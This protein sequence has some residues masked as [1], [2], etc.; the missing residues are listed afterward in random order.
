MSD[1]KNYD[2]DTN[3]LNPGIYTEIIAKIQSSN[4]KIPNYLK[5]SILRKNHYQ[6]QNQNIDPNLNI[7]QNQAQ[8][9]ED[10]YFLR[11]FPTIENISSHKGYSSGYQ[12]LKITGKGFNP[13]DANLKVLID[14]NEC[15]KIKVNSQTEI[16]CITKE[17]IFVNNTIMIEKLD[18]TTESKFKNYKG[19][20]GLKFKKE[21]ISDPNLI[22]E[23]EI[24]LETKLPIIPEIII[25]EDKVIIRPVEPPFP[26]SPTDSKEIITHKHTP[27][28]IQPRPIEPEINPPILLSPI[29]KPEPILIQ[30]QPIENNEEQIKIQPENLNPE[31]I[32]HDETIPQI[33]P[34]IILPPLTVSTPTIEHEETSNLD[35]IHT[36]EITIPL[37]TTS[38]LSLI[39]EN[40]THINIHNHN[41][42]Q[43]QNKIHYE[44]E[45]ILETTMKLNLPKYTHASFN[46]FFV[47][48]FTGKYK[49][50]SSFSGIHSKIFLNKYI[51][52]T[53]SPI[54]II[55]NHNFPIVDIDLEYGNY[56]TNPSLTQSDWID[57]NKDQK[58][59]I[60]I[61][62]NILKEKNHF[63]LGVEIDPDTDT[64]EVNI[65]QSNFNNNKVPIIKKIN[66]IPKFSRDLY[67]IPILKF[68]ETF[69]TMEFYCQGLN[70]NNKIEIYSNDTLKNLYDKFQKMH[71]TIFKKLTMRK[72]S[73][74]EFMNLIPLE[75]ELGEHVD[76]N[77]TENAN[78]NENINVVNTSNTNE[79]EHENELEDNFREFSYSNKI[80][81]EDLNKITEELYGIY[82]RFDLFN[83]QIKI[84]TDAINNNNSTLIVKK[85][86]GHTFIFFIDGYENERKYRLENYCYTKNSI[87]KNMNHVKLLRKVK[88]NLEG[89]Y[90]LNVYNKDSNENQTSQ[91]IDL[92]N[93]NYEKIFNNILFM[94][95]EYE[96][97]G[98]INSIEKELFLKYNNKVKFLIKK[99]FS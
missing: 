55:D 61:H 21:K 91:L 56:F 8:P 66:I 35:N 27:I 93:P 65:S 12:I 86:I 63:Q 62:N 37:T 64:D 70:N 77:K 4:T 52:G 33:Q 45:I 22:K 9:S 20:K 11:V 59:P 50:I 57:L 43:N 48:P 26:N 72:Y 5:R 7:N 74:D 85:I 41:G 94:Y 98:L 36:T 44:E 42:T 1:F 76:L 32:Q 80:K 46:G 60:E 99:S 31:P 84:N 3:Y 78:L 47:A 90:K 75:E 40:Y 73:L 18:I 58:Y 16:S 34:R 92:S 13:K 68:N 25:N 14:E 67:E 15:H 19:T 88:G 87:S 6:N 71:P 95:N 30:P 49:F 2:C 17:N 69:V 79:N 53:I 10:S 38:K 89:K 24:F 96:A 39:P 97:F 29:P 51:N 23:I 81:F 83:K 54:K 28:L 82:N